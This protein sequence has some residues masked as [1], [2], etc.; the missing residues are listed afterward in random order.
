MLPARFW[1]VLGVLT[2]F[3]VG[4]FP[5][6]LLLLRLHDLGVPTMGVVLAYA[7]YN[8]AYAA[9][10]YPPDVSPT[11]CPR[12]WCTRPSSIQALPTPSVQA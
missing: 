7:G 4:N 11:G 6:A 2:V 5:D 3:G 1:Q 8:L 12:A 9:L 10:S